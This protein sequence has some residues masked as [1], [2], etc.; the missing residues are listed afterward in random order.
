MST[1][2]TESNCIGPYFIFGK[3]GWVLPDFRAASSPIWRTQPQH[4]STGRLYFTRYTDSNGNEILSEYTSSV[5]KATGT[6]YIDMDYSYVADDGSYEYTL[7]HVELPQTDENRTYYT[8]S[9]RFLK[10]TVLSDVKNQ[11]ELFTYDS[12]ESGFVYKNASY[13]AEDNTTAVI[14]NKNTGE[15]S[16]IYVLG[17]EAPYFS[18]YGYDK[19]EKEPTYGANFGLIV[20][21]SYVTAGGVE[22]D[23]NFV[24]KN[25]YDGT[26]NSGSLSLNETEMVFYRNDV[27][28]LQLILLP[29][30]EG[31]DTSSDNV[32]YVIEDS[33]THKFKLTSDS[34]EIVDDYYVPS[35][36]A[37]E[38]EAV[39]TATGGRN[40]CVIKADGFTKLCVPKIYEQVDGEWVEYDYHARDNDGYSVE[41][42][43]GYYSYSFVCDMGDDPANASRTFKIVAE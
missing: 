6:S 17:K 36:K 33:V 21:D 2:V 41:Y 14:T 34:C 8:L 5:L 31:E 4:N 22:W 1:G 29:Y 39:V 26:V 11:L 3:D 7:R 43:F 10:T 23:G 32:D 40:N 20:S 28:E 42:E 15:Y 25:E 38:N 13:R 19:W 9:L 37:V 18:Y 16:D 27:I 24:F 12:R 30:G 35:V